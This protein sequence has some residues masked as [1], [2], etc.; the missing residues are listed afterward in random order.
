MELYKAVSN[1]KKETVSNVEKEERNI[2]YDIA[3]REK[4]NVSE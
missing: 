3:M 1:A 2:V 4:S